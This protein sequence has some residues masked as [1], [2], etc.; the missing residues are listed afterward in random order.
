MNP[1]KSF[2][3]SLLASML[4]LGAVSTPALAAANAPALPAPA[5]SGS[6]QAASIVFTPKSTNFTA[7]EYEARITIPVISGLADKTYQAQL[8]AEL[9]KHA[10]E[11]LK[12]VQ[13]QSKRDAEL[14][15]K[16]GWEMRPHVLDI[17]YEVYTTGKLLSF[18]VTTYTYSGGAHGMTNVQY[19]NV[20]NL[21]KTHNLQLSELF[22]PGYDYKNVLN[23]LIKQQIKTEERKTGNK[24]PYWFEGISNNQ[25][26]SFKNGTLLIHFGQ[27]EIAPYAAGMPAFTIPRHQFMNLLK[28]GIRDL[29]K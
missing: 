26:F 9:E 28:P 4:I 16:E 1:R 10:A 6:Q 18:G 29:L 8:N 21:E 17:S 14:A 2:L 15:K 27:Y 7:K 5:S 25:G 20:P 22:Q 11:S 19:F 24:L 3:S 13:Q 23:N 12:T